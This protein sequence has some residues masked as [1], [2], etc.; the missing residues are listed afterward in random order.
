MDFADDDQGSTLHLAQK[1]LQSSQNNR[2]FEQ[3]KYKRNGFLAVVEQA[4]VLRQ[5]P[6]DAKWNEHAFISLLQAEKTR[7]FLKVGLVNYEV[8]SE[9]P[10]LK[11]DPDTPE[12][13]LEV[14]VYS[15]RSWH[16]QRVAIAAVSGTGWNVTAPGEVSGWVAPY[17]AASAHGQ[18][19]RGNCRQTTT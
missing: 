6:G 5:S 18:C 4:F 8:F 12:Q 19:L 14:P 15:R 10:L 3:L 1:Q 9:K 7:I 16:Q 17:R 13:D 2:C 11:G